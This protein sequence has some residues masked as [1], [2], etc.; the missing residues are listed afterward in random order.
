MSRWID[1][2]IAEAPRAL[3]SAGAGR[4]ILRLALIP[5]RKGRRE[6]SGDLKDLI[7]EALESA[8]RPPDAV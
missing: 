4:R 7:T 5:C 2:V 6:P 3:T 8:S 1:P